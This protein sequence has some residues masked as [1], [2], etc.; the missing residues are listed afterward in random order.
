[1]SYYSYN[2]LK[3]YF[4]KGIQS[5]SSHLITLILILS[6][7][8]Y[9]VSPLFSRLFYWSVSF[10]SHV[11]YIPRISHP[12]SFNLSNNLSAN[13]EYPHDT[14]F[15]SS[16]SYFLPFSPILQHP[17]LKHLSMF[18]INV[19]DQIS[20]PYK[21]GKIIVLYILSSC[22]KMADDSELIGSKHTSYLF[23]T[24]FIQECNF[25]LL[26]SFLNIWILRFQRI[27]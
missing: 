16:S 22:I 1:M 20:L 27:C 26:V 2:S 25:I 11:C 19:K 8:L 5:T 13:Y 17:V 3:L 6:C 10:H 4:T 14:F 21:T 9:L 23:C 12:P 18:F 7:D 15:S 24:F